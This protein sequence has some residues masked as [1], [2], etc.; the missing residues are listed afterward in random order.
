MKGI[1]LAGG[2]GSRLL[3]LTK[4]TNKHLLPIYDQQM[5]QYPLG[6]L[7]NAGIR[8]ILIVSGPGHAG[9]FLE[10]LNSGYD[11]GIDIKYA[12]QEKPLGIA[13]AL[14]VAKGETVAVILGDNIIEDNIKLDVENFKEGAK[15]FLK[16]VEN[17]NEF[18]VA[19]ID[20]DK[21]IGIEEKPAKPK[22]DYAVIGLYI[23]DQKVFSYIDRLS[24]SDRNELEITD[25]NNLYLK[26]NMLSYG[27]IQGYWLDA[28]SHEGLFKASEFIRNIRI[29]NDN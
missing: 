3:P 8:D 7:K 20:G 6:T 12:I 27:M 19:E 18:G 22:S 5:I 1:I 14:W 28:G 24:Y 9:Q 11:E 29:Q 23:Y 10:L 25:L 21:V 2:T 17:P 26:D 4:T 16:K 15:I 13:H